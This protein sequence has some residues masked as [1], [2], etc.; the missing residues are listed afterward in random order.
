MAV[1]RIAQIPNLKIVN[2]CAYVHTRVQ[3]AK[4]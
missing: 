4:S 3:K 2:I 1:K